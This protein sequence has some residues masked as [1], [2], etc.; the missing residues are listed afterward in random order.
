MLVTSAHAR[1][2]VRN[3]LTSGIGCVQSPSFPYEVPLPPKFSYRYFR[4]WCLQFCLWCLRFHKWCLCF[5]KWCLQFCLW[6]LRFHKW[7]LQFCLWCLRFH[8]WCLRFCKWCFKYS[9]VW[10][11]LSGDLTEENWGS[12]SKRR[13]P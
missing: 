2:D 10:E 12:V 6:C 4:K 3:F 8:K 1:S 5:R 9:A 13:T 11:R 7:C